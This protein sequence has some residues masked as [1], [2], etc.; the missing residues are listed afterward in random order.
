MER[1]ILHSDLNS[2]YA[3]VE[4]LYN[5]SLRG[6]PVSVCG[7][8]DLRHRIVLASTPEAKAY[9]VKTG[10]AVWQAQQREF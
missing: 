2:F 5:P 6:K 9:G 7:S 4:C 10:D 1:T 3:S 8:V